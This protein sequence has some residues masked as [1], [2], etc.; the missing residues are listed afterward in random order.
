LY[1]I[2]SEESHLLIVKPKDK[3][4]YESINP[5]PCD[6]FQ[7]IKSFIEHAHHTYKSSSK[8]PMRKELLMSNRWIDRW[9]EITKSTLLL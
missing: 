5:C 9:W 6:L 4:Q 2:N 7:T 3:K 1:S 8:N